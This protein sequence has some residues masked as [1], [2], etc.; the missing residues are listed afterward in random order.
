MQPTFERVILKVEKVK[1]DNNFFEKV[2]DPEVSLIA[3]AK[4]CALEIQNHLNKK[5]VYNGDTNKILED[6]ET[7]LLVLT[8]QTNI[9]V[10]L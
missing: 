3:F 6:N 2:A 9:L 10:L 1:N 4:D 7:H 5:V 8:H